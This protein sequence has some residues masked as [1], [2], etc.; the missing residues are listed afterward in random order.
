M[1]QQ[2]VSLLRPKK[3]NLGEERRFLILSTTGLGDTLW[4]TPA[5]R[6][7]RH[8]FPTSYI[9][10]LTSPLGA[11]LLKHNR[12]IDTLFTL[13]NPLSLYFEL[14]AQHITHVL[15][16]HTS[17][18]SV[19]PLSAL[20]G[21][22]EIIGSYGINKGLDSLLTE[23]LDNLDQHEIQR[24]LDIVAAVG[25]Q[26]LQCSME[27]VL[28]PEDEKGA[29]EALRPLDLLPYLPLVGLHPGAKDRFK[30]WP[31]THFIELGR[32]LMANLGC[33]ILVTGTKEEK[34]LVEHVAA[35]I[36]GAA[37]FTH[38]PLLPMAAL[39]KRMHLLIANDTGPMHLGIASQVPT[40]GLFSPT[41]PRLCGPYFAPHSFPLAKPPTCRP[42][43]K[44]RCLSP[45]CLMQIGVDEAYAAALQLFYLK[46][47]L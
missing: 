22:R 42:C 23:A 47:T 1:I 12:H 35:G 11:E 31:A 27:I 9:A 40:L 34:A 30:Q 5:I 17:Q 46:K 45:F 26:P 4:A 43:I 36:P 32:R 41:H 25:A 20:L 6:A 7:L 37:P 13:R 2:G 8:S 29:D 24:R 39:I 18:R 33:Q 44:K 19:L 21:A 28:S 14:K 10:L 3:L 15:V 38:L 16:F